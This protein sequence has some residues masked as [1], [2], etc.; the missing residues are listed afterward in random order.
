MLPTL[1]L[2]DGNSRMAGNFLLPDLKMVT[3]NEKSNLISQALNREASMKPQMALIPLLAVMMV[4]TAVPSYVMGEGFQAQKPSA[5]A[6]QTPPVPP[7]TPGE[8]SKGK[9]ATPPKPIKTADPIY[10]EEARQ[11]RVQ[12]DVILE[13]VVHKDG[14]ASVNKVVQA[15]GYGLDNSAKAAIEQSTFAPGTLDG[16]PVDVT[17]RTTISFHL[18][19]R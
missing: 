19:G 4:L 1:S 9:S 6:E 17:L 15:L 16:E 12:G 18:A 2:L 8:P 3:G 5:P 10:T 14:T 13:I 7:P 11:A